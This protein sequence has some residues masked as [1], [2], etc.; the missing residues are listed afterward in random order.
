VRNR[1]DACRIWCGYLIE[2]VQFEDLDVDVGIIL[3]WIFNKKDGE[4]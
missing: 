2:K 3:T 1:K 4:T